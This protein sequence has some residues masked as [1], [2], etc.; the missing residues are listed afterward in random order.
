[1]ISYEIAMGLSLIGIILTF[2]SLDLHEAESELITGYYTEYSGA[3]QATFMLVDFVE[4]I[5]VAGL[6][7]TLFF[8]GW[9]VPFL[10]RDGFHFPW[11]GVLSLPSLLVPLIQVASF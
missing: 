7:T 11:G 5:I 6:V 3:K 4:S 9:Q 8:G 10:L 2:G 1:M